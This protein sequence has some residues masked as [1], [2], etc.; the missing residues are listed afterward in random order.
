MKKSFLI[1]LL[2]TINTFVFAQNRYSIQKGYSIGLNFNYWQSCYLGAISF[3]NRFT[4]KFG[5]FV[6]VESGQFGN[7]IAD[8][9]TKKWFGHVDYPGL[10]GR[11]FYKSSNVGIQLAIGTN[12]EFNI[13][14]FLSITPGIYIVNGIYNR[15]Y[16][17]DGGHLSY[18]TGKYTI[19]KDNS[20]E[21]NLGIGFNVFLEWIVSKRVRL[22]TGF[23]L[24]FYVLNPNKLDISNQTHHPLRGTNPVLVFGISYYLKNK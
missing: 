7:F 17:Y 21:Y 8:G 19:F 24:P 14:H 6:S 12:Y 23:K 22:L 10:N 1:V 20:L 5:Y 9:K 18:I 11:T 13:V 3:Q 4:S 2:I 15:N 16:E